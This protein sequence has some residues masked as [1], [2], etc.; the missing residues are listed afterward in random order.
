MDTLAFQ[1]TIWKYFKE[2][3]RELPWRHEKDPYKVLVS[4]VMLQQTQVSRVVPK[5]KEWL[6]KFPTVESLA[7]ASLRD[8][9]VVWQGLGYNRRGKYLKEAAGK[10]VS[11]KRYA[12]LR[13][14]SRGSGNP[15]GN[16]LYKS[17]VKPG[18]TGEEMVLLLQEL[19]GIGHATAAAIVVYAFDKP[20]VF[21]ETNIRAVY[22]YFFFK[23]ESHISDKQIAEIVAKTLDLTNPRDWYYALTD[24]GNMLKNKE[25]F[26]NTQSKHYVIQS[27]FKGSK[28]QMRGQILRFLSTHH[29]IDEKDLLYELIHYKMNSIEIIRELVKERMIMKVGSVYKIRD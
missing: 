8:V 18:M 28:R 13:C 24:Y 6:E 16:L 12:F 1:S 2:H 26:Q 20:V 19:P 25:K 14:H 3:G 23:K 9:L 21:I 4:E 22:L 27:K 29:E 17:R 15:E 7:K 11:D 5:Y 10:I